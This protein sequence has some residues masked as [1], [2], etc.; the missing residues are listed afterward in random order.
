MPLLC[1]F[2][3]LRLTA[4][5]ELITVSPPASDR[6]VR[7]AYQPPAS[8]TFLSVQTSHQQPASGTFLS[9][10]ISISHQPNEQSK[11][12]GEARG[13]RRRH[14]T[15]TS[16]RITADRKEVAISCNRKGRLFCFLTLFAKDFHK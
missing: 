15:L 8:G 7:L 4:G 14:V 6:P 16:A 11:C 5:G 12:L 10:Q 1:A 13:P 3:P 9:E 2:A